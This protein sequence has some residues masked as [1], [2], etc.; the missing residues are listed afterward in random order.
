MTSI[1][2]NFDLK[3]ASAGLCKLLLAIMIEPDVDNIRLAELTGYSQ[4]HIRRLR[5]H[6]DRLKWIERPVP[7]QTDELPDKLRILDSF[8]FDASA[9]HSIAEDYSLRL[10]QAG[11][12]Y[13]S[14]AKHV[15]NP[16]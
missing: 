16:Q 3:K 9:A 7:Q 4:R 5:Y 2:H 6:I 12:D 10:I 11:I 15:R 14:Q 13:V 8:G 1:P